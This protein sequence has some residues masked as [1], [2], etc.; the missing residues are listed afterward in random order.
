MAK[1]LERQKIE[2]AILAIF[3]S[4][5]DAIYSDIAQRVNLELG[6]SISSREVGE[7]RRRLGIG[8]FQLLWSKIQATASAPFEP[9]YHADTNLKVIAILMAANCV[10]L[11]V[12]RADR[13]GSWPR[14]K[15][16]DYSDVTVVTPFGDIPWTTVNR[17]NDAE[18]KAFNSGVVNRL[19]TVLCCLL[20]P[21]FMPDRM[22]FL[23]YLK[24]N[25][26]A[27]SDDPELDQDLI[28]LY[29]KPPKRNTLFHE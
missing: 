15:T 19:Y 9:P 25:Y 11:P 23:K 5:P 7:I 13:E 10:R 2:A 28:S 4:D 16:G 12:T 3:A 29:W 22:A 6:V 1:S 20:D 24:F 21:D 14:T 18:L 8:S 17:L 26:P 27:E